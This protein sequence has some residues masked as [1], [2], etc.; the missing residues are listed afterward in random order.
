MST[1]FE[2]R[3]RRHIVW[4]EFVVIFLLC[5]PLPP[6]VFFLKWR[7]V[8]GGVAE[9]AFFCFSLISKN[10]IPKSYLI[11]KGSPIIWRKLKDQRFIRSWTIKCHPLQIKFVCSVV[12][13]KESLT[14]LLNT[15][16]DGP[17]CLLYTL[18]FA[19]FAQVDWTVIFQDPEEAIAVLI[20]G[21]HWEE[22]LRL[23][24]SLS[25]IIREL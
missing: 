15:M 20:D 16:V 4:V 14:T 6:R 23:V 11:C 17:S 24:S 2:S 18:N 5:P 10:N 7:G 19:I 13:C 8:G 22:A 1:W 9:V 21:M 3:R 12:W 25:D